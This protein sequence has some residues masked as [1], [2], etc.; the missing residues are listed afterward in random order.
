ML[1][2]YDQMGDFYYEFVQRELAAPQ[3]VLNLSIRT[4]LERLGDV[5]GMKFCDLACGEGHFARRLSERGALVTGVDLSSNL[6]AHARRQSQGMAITYVQ[7][8][9]QTLTHLDPASFDLVVSN[10]ALMDIAQIDTTFGAVH[11]ILRQGGRF[12]F[13]LLH[14]CFETPFHTPE[15]PIEVDEQGNFVAC[16]VMRYAEEGLWY[17]GGVGIRGT[18]GAYHRTLSTYVN[19]LIAVGFAI[20]HLAEPLVSPTD[21]P[22]TLTHQASRVPRILLVEACKQ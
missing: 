4:M 14:P 15:R 19:T 10:L 18:H 2:V 17:S 3:S 22:D 7:D 16:R 8:D 9:A 6:L 11:R 5:R 20:T 1:S 21:Y 12:L 13:T